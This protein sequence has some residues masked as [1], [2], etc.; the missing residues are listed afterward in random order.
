M[1]A[2]PASID[3]RQELEQVFNLPGN[4]KVVD[5]VNFCGYALAPMAV[6]CSGPWSFPSMAVERILAVREGVLWAHEYGHAKGL[7]HRPDTDTDALMHPIIEVPHAK[8]SA[9]ECEAFRR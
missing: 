4:Y 1:H 8:I 2:G 3:S 9:P 7:P 5:D 6:G